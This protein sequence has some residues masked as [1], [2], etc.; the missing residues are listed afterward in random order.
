MVIFVYWPRLDGF[1]TFR[2]IFLLPHNNMLSP[3]HAKLCQHKTFNPKRHSI[4]KLC[5]QD[6]AYRGSLTY[7]ILAWS[8]AEHI[9]LVD[10]YA[11][12]ASS[13]SVA[14]NN[15]CLNHL[16]VTIDNRKVCLLI[17][18]VWSLVWHWSHVFSWHHLLSILDAL[19]HMWICV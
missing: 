12:C 17:V 18:C 1:I 4:L 8:T 11:K 16:A 2:M 7:I 5:L 15:F 13:P 19:L 6:F 9:L 10:S 3:T 14:H